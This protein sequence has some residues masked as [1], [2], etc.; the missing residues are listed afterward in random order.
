MTA[1]SVKVVAIIPS[2]D[3]STQQAAAAPPVYVADSTKSTWENAVHDYLFAYHNFYEQWG[4][5][6]RRD[7]LH[8]DAGST[9]RRSV[10]TRWRS[11]R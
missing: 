8:V 7:V 11:R 6:D 9:R 1:D 4:R 5:C 2:A 10:P 3:R